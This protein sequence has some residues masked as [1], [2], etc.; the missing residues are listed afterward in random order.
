MKL[1][2]QSLTRADA[3]KGYNRALRT[4]LDRVKDPQTQ[5]E[6][7][8]RNRT[9][10]RLNRHHGLPLGETPFPKFRSLLVISLLAAKNSL[11]A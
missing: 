7:H 4:L 9:G 5:I 3:W 10:V 11:I 6:V 8:G 2:Y 1:W